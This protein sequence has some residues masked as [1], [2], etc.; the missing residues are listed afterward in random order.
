MQ[1]FPFG[2]PHAWG[3]SAEKP[4]TRPSLTDIEARI[5]GYRI[6][7]LL[8]IA[9]QDA[10]ALAAALREVLAVTDEYDQGDGDVPPEDGWRLLRDI[11]AAIAERIDI[12]KE[13]DRG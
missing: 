3:T 1:H 9:A 5:N 4:D 13:D 11:R 2:Y 12:T 8:L 6:D 7:D 10:P